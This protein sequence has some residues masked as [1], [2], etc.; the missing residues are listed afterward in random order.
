MVEQKKCESVGFMKSVRALFMRLSGNGV[1]H[2]MCLSA[3]RSAGE[4]DSQAYNSSVAHPYINGKLIHTINYG[5]VCMLC[6]AMQHGPKTWTRTFLWEPLILFKSTCEIMCATFVIIILLPLISWSL[7][8]V[9]RGRL[10]H[11]QIHIRSVS[12]SHQQCSLSS[13]SPGLEDNINTPTHREQ[14]IPN[15]A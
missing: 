12:A 7:S 4:M 3:R 15:E 2:L 13:C 14:Q 1:T 10:S 9:W 5:R 11:W 6:S 8:A